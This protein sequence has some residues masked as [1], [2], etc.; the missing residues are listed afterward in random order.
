MALGPR[1]LADERLNAEGEPLQN[2]DK[3]RFG[4]TGHGKARQI[5]HIAVHHQLA[6]VQHQQQAEVELGNQAWQ[7]GKEQVRHGGKVGHQIPPAEAKPRPG[8]KEVAKTDQAHRTLCHQGGLRGTDQSQPQ[9]THHDVVE[10][11]IEH[12][13][14][15]H[16][17]H[18]QFRATIVAQQIGDSQIAGQQQGTAA[19]PGEVVARLFPGLGALFN[20]QSQQDIGVGVIEQHRR[21]APRVRPAA[22]GR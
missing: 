1:R 17:H 20:P 4:V 2:D 18:G 8:G 11:D 21:N 15:A 14:A 3:D 12:G 13:A 22:R 7:T 19:N 10:D 16:Q 9:P 6:V 5:L